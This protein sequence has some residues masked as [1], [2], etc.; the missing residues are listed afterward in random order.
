[1]VGSFFQQ[2]ASSADL[3]QPLPSSQPAPP[4][5]PRRHHKTGHLTEGSVWRPRASRQ[6]DHLSSCH[7]WSVRDHYTESRPSHKNTPTSLLPAPNR[8]RLQGKKVKGQF[9]ELRPGVMSRLEVTVDGCTG[10]TYF[11]HKMDRETLKTAAILILKVGHGVLEGTWGVFTQSEDAESLRFLYL[12]FAEWYGRIKI[13]QYSAVF[14]ICAAGVQLSSEEQRHAT[15]WIGWADSESNSD[16]YRFY[17]LIYRTG[18]R[19]R[20]DIGVNS[21]D[22][23]FDQLTD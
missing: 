1:M 22:W 19:E 7:T 18:K 8:S 14:F 4:P 2:P 5:P 11:S 15:N 16:I 12:T 3:H 10:H 20:R 17:F 6:D 9:L 23:D 13:N 21:T